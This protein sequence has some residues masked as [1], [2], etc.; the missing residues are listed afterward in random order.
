MGGLPGQRRAE[1]QRAGVSAKLPSVPAVD[2]G[3]KCCHRFIS[4]PRLHLVVLRLALLA[5]A[6][7]ELVCGSLHSAEESSRQEPDMLAVIT[8]ARLPPVVC[9]LAGPHAGLIMEML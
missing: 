2:A 7:L 1:G 3:Y 5:F 9:K 6:A 4:A 8:V